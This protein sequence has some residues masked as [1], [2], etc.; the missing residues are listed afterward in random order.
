MKLRA[1]QLAKQ[2]TQSDQTPPVYLVTGDEALL[3]DEASDLIRKSLRQHDFTERELMHVDAQFNWEQIFQAANSLSLFAERR[4]IE[5]RLGSH[6]INKAISALLQRY[7]DDPAPDVVL[8]ILADRM[9]AGAKKSAWWKRIEQLG[10]IVEVWP[11][12]SEQLPQWLSQRAALKG[13]EFDP[14][15]LQVLTDRVE[16]NLLAAQQELEKLSL[17]YPNGTISSS[18]ISEAVS[19]SSRFDIFSLTDA[20]LNCQPAR[21]QHIVQSLKQEGIEAPVVLWA[22]T[23]ELRV[24]HNLIEAIAQGENYDQL[25][26]RFRIWGQRKTLVRV[27]CRRLSPLL[28]EALLQQAATADGAIKGLNRSDPWLLISQISLRLAGVKLATLEHTS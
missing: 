16:G 1:D 22:L 3:H 19:D 8:L 23:R 15:A 5:V 7:L 21:C 24:L 27:A 25:T 17:L 10:V 18:D 11:I 12:E 4:I 26:Q 28:L 20:A 6:K 2:L 13:L 14:E 9:D